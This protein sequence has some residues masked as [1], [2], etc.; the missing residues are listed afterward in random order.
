M[1]DVLDSIVLCE[2]YHDRAFLQG[3]LLKIGCADPG[4]QP[5]GSRKPIQDPDG[6]T[7]RGGQ[8]A[9]LRILDELAM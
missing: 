4:E 5:D 8:F 2:G 9:F 7:V 1:N 6:R 3:A